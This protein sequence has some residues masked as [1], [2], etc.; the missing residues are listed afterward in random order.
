MGYGFMWSRIETP[1]LPRRVGL[2]AVRL[3]V[4][5]PDIEPLAECHLRRVDVQGC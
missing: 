2:P 1:V 5:V 4:R 3:G